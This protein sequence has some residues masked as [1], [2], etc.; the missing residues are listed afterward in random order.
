[1]ASFQVRGHGMRKM[2]KGRALFGLDASSQVLM[3]VLLRYSLRK[4]D[5]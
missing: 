4:P 3:T 1:M 5:F 2:R